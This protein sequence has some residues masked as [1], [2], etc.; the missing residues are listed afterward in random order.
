[1]QRKIAEFPEQA[2]EWAVEYAMKISPSKCKVI[3]FTRVRVEDPLI[4]SLSGTLIL[5]VSSC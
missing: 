2:R 5:E 3:R 4:Y 1:M